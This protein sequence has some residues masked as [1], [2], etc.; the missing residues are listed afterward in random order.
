M[1]EPDNPGVG[2]AALLVDVLEGDLDPALLVRFADDPSA[3]DPKE[4]WM[5]E[6][7]LATSPQY[8][9]QLEVLK[10]FDFSAA[11]GRNSPPAAISRASAQRS[12][13]LV[14]RLIAYRADRL[15]SIMPRSHTDFETTI[16]RL[17]ERMDRLITTLP[18]LRNSSWADR[19]RR[20][21]ELRSRA[22]EIDLSWTA[23][24]S[25]ESSFSKR[26]R[27]ARSCSASSIA[28]SG[29][30]GAGQPTRAS[31]AISARAPSSSKPGSFP[32]AARRASRV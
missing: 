10:R 3:L 32:S 24:P 6:M 15:L 11:R 5:V 18:I 19:I 13:G 14:R 7:H 16:V 28:S 17:L 30:S 9:D 25:S 29:C 21:R 31:A 12:S 23:A 26:A 22:R 8:R 20:A 1:S 2:L 4:R 27:R